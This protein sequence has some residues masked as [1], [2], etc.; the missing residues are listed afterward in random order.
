[1]SVD[2]V[3]SAD[4]SIVIFLIVVVELSLLKGLPSVYPLI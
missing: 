3:D 1:M 4:L 2:V